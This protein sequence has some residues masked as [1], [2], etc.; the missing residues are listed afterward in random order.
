M[1][2]NGDSIANDLLAG[3]RVLETGPRLA[4]AV[5]GRLYA[6]LGADVIKVEPSEGD[7]V[8]LRGP[9]ANGGSGSGG[10]FLSQNVDKRGLVLDT[11]DPAGRDRF[12]ELA[13]GADVIVSSWHPGDIERQG[14]DSG[15]LSVVNPNAVLVYLTPFGLEGPRSRHRGSDLIVFHSS[16]I[17]KSLI[18]PVADPDTTPPVRAVGEQSEFV[19]GVAAACASMFGLYR[20]SSGGGGAVIDVSM[21]EALAFMDVVA[22]TAPSFNAKGRPRRLEKKP[23]PSLSILPAADGFVAISPREEHQW[24]LWLGVL[25]NPGW[26]N[27]PRFADRKL[28]EENSEAVYKHLSE[29]SSQYPKMDIFKMAQDSRVPAFPL[30][31]PAEHLESEQ[32][33]TREFF[34]EVVS[35]GRTYAVPGVPYKTEVGTA[36]TAEPYVLHDVIR[37]GPIDWS[38]RPAT[39]PP[40]TM[41]DVNRRSLPL[42]GI[43]VA[44]L[45]WVIAGP[46]CTRY[47][48][49][50]GAEIVKIETAKRADPGRAGQLHDVLG[51]G[52]LGI[53]LNLKSDE[54]L[55]AIKKL[56][57]QSDIVVENFAPGVMDRLGLSWDVLRELQPGLVM[58]SASGTGQTGPTKHVAAY[59]TLLQVYTGFAGQNGYRGQSPSIGMA[60]ADP[61][62]GMLLAFSATAALRASRRSGVG[63]HVDFS[64][65][66]AML[67]TMPGPL[68]EYQMKCRESE[69]QGNDDE[70]FFPHGAFHC[71]GSDSWVAI[72]VTQDSEWRALASEIGAPAGSEDW[73]VAAR[74]SRGSEIVS[75]IEKWASSKDPS[76]ASAEL[77]AAGVPAAASIASAELLDDAHLNERGFLAMLKDRNGDERKMPTLPWRWDCGEPPQFGTPPALG[78]DTA[79]VLKEVLGYEDGQI[80]A[81]RAAGALE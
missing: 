20:A 65:V 78:G 30:M 22:M 7:P 64:M 63:Q 49:S 50:M 68:L 32:L 35:G 4:S 52:K 26:G 44:D 21:Q 51:Q 46:T 8:R 24:K 70:I 16:G 2:R 9:H 48:A 67:S 13:R 47:L 45:S 12:D 53:T 69:P 18:G 1:N 10:M 40:E 39:G 42:K 6:E 23:G 34:R 17:A 58:V 31:N 73:N 60:W 29:W 75:L 56:I 25:G 79:T 11:Q 28:R 59:G 80:S 3:F 76:T 36:R 57:A 77:Q 55:A 14:V 62:C 61:L 33:K 71:A 5:A 54:G 72:A 38:A 74:R 27:D 19:S 37:D 66:E 41:A 81:M 15:R 43:R